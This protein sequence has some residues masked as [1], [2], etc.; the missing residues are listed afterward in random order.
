MTTHTSVTYAFDKLDLLIVTPFHDDSVGFHSPQGLRID[1]TPEHIPIVEQL[2]AA[3][4]AKRDKTG[5]EVD[6][7]AR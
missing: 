7:C 3:L 2:L 6:P 4:I 5:P 1:L